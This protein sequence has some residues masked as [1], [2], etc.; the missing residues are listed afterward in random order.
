MRHVSITCKN[1]PGL[2]WSTK[3]IA[4]S[5]EHGYNGARSL[6]FHGKVVMHGGGPKL[7]MDRSGVQTSPCAECQC[8]VDQ[9]TVA[10]E[11]ILLS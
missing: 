9:L 1:H 4:W 10:P 11:D 6:H 3:S 5:N 2:R 7:F 8:K